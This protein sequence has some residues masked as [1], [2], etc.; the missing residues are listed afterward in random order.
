M[1]FDFANFYRRFVE[2]YAKITRSLTELFK[3]NKNDKQIDFFVFENDAIKTFVVLIVVFT[4]TF[5]LIHFNFKNR[6]MIKID[7]SK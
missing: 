1:F 5:M 4:Q 7:V 6:I 3:K 2:N